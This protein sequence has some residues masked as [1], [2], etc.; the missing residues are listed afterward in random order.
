MSPESFILTFQG[1][2]SR[3]LELFLTAGFVTAAAAIATETCAMGDSNVEM[4]EEEEDAGGIVCNV[5]E[6]V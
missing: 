4:E 2:G 6:L 3:L 5:I 1:V